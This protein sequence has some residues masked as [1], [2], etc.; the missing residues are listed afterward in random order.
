FGGVD[1]LS[2]R[3]MDR[4][5]FARPEP[6]ILRVE[7][8]ERDD[9]FAHHFRRRGLQALVELC[10]GVP[11]IEELRYAPCSYFVGGDTQVVSPKTLTKA[12]HHLCVVE[13]HVELGVEEEA[14][15][16]GVGR[17][18][19]EGFVVDQNELRMKDPAGIVQRVDAE[20]IGG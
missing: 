20:T 12:L 15:R 5:P 19:R 17:A 18:D 3:Q 10:H 13:H 6:G 7:W 2:K 8:L 14:S 11:A 1:G 4:A 9:S 16:V